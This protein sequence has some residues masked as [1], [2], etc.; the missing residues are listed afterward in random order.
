MEKYQLNFAARMSSMY[1]RSSREKKA[2]RIIKTL[3]EYFGE[4]KLSSL[5]VLDVGSSTGIIDNILSKKFKKVIGS[6]IDESAIDY[7]NKTFK[8]RRL[9]FQIGDAMNLKFKGNT[10]DV[11]I[12]AQVYEHV[13]N[14]KKLFSEIYRVLKPGGICYL[15]ALNKL[16]IWEPHY[17]LP[18]LSWLPKGVANLY[19]K[20]TGKGNF[21][22]ETLCTYWELEG[23]SRKFVIHDFT[24]KIILDP[25]KYGY[26]DSIPLNPALLIP[27]QLVAYFYKFF[28]P[29][30]FW[31]LVKPSAITNKN[32]FNTDWIP[33]PAFLYRNYLYKKIVNRLPKDSFFLEVGTGNGALLNYLVKSGFKGEAIDISLEA[34]EIARI[35]L[36]ERD[37]GIIKHTDLFSYNTKKLYDIVLCFE[38]LEHIENDTFAMRKIYELLKPGGT[39]VLSVPAHEREWSSIDELKGH[40]RRYEKHDLRDKLRSSGFQINEMYSYGFPVLWLLRKISSSGRFLQTKSKRRDMREKTE[41]SSI[42]REYN[43][44]LQFLVNN[45]LILFPLFKLMDLFLKTDLGIGYIA[46]ARKTGKR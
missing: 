35:L 31:L 8:K 29:T 7:A 17:N 32:Q 33:T 6:D 44:K 22:F 1:D 13:S 36:G 9:K 5:T 42:E 15:A 39:F 41:K 12:C 37:N 45:K 20:L 30:F 4:E 3:G 23:L 34:I 19:L 11:V 27:L 18:F 40:F 25:K 21:Y 46:V 10:F 16:R 2:Y 24:R 28:S 14:Q 26:E 38:T 43:P